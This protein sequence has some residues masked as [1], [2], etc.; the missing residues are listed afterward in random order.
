[1]IAA[2]A[3]EHESAEVA[4]VVTSGETREA[5]LELLRRQGPVTAVLEVRETEGTLV[6]RTNAPASIEVDGRT[7][8]SDRAARVVAGSHRV[9]VTAPG[10]ATWTG[11]ADVAVGSVRVVNVRLA[12][13]DGLS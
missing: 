3:P 4:I 13:S 9:R 5:R 6:F 7:V 1:M 11:Q 2:T 8:A 10:F 12:P